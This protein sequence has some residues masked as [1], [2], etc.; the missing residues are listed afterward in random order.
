MYKYTYFYLN[1][2]QWYVSIL[3]EK[4]YK[5]NKQTKSAFSKLRP[6]SLIL[7]YVI[8]N[9]AFHLVFFKTD[10]YKTVLTAF[11]IGYLFESQRPLASSKDRSIN[12]IPPKLFCFTKL[13]LNFAVSG[14]SKLIQMPFTSPLGKRK[15]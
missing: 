12:A 13:A 11:K 14:S 3:V 2:K 4:Y 7:L 15:A 10:Y 6:I 5:L 1:T 8:S 9:I